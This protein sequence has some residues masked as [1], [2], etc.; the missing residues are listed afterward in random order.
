MVL[1]TP[2]LDF[3]SILKG[4]GRVWEEFWN[5]FGRVWRLKNYGFFGSRFFILFS[6]AG[7]FGRGFGRRQ[8][9]LR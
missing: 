1:E 8:N 3:N 9:A 2:G 4:L 7:A 6:V 5:G